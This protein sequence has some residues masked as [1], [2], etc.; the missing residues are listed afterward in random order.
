MAR[1][2]NDDLL[3]EDDLTAAFLDDE[4]DAVPAAAPLMEDESIMAEEPTEV[5]RT[6]RF[7][8]SI[9]S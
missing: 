4:I 8:R 3:M 7:S 2:Q 9:S 6:G 1:K 5:G